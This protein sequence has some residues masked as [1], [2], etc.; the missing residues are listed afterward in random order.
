VGDGRLDIVVKRNVHH[1]RIWSAHPQ[2]VLH[3]GDDELVTLGVPGTTGRIAR[4]GEGIEAMRATFRAGDWELEPR[5]W[6][7]FVAVTRYRSRRRFSIAHLF[8]PTSGEFLAWYVNFER[9]IARHDDG[10]VIDTLTYWLNLIV[11]PDGKTFWKDTDQWRWACETALYPSTEVQVVEELRDDLVDAA[12]AGSGPFDGAWT[13]WAPI[14][15]DPL[16][17]PHYWD[18]PARA[19]DEC[20]AL[21]HR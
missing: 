2:L 12:T 1:G 6:H 18:R 9:P 7:R 17:L 15:L 19:L 10:L 4:W 8:D 14:E 5:M 16:D 13:E 11:L 21:D 20:E 3:D